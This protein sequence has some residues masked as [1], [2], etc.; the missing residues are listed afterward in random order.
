MRES[1]WYC[2]HAPSVTKRWQ[3]DI[4][5]HTSMP[6]LE[7]WWGYK[8]DYWGLYYEVMQFGP[9]GRITNFAAD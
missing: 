8:R 1:E 9:E 4:A 2:P 6:I 3:L 5:T 7:E